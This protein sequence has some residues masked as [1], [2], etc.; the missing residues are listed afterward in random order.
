[1]KQEEQL[2]RQGRGSDPAVEVMVALTPAHQ[3]TRQSCG[4]VPPGPPRMWEPSPDPQSGAA[5]HPFSP[6]PLACHVALPT[7]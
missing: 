1:M 4:T 5:L 3:L 6:S 2:Q 7:G